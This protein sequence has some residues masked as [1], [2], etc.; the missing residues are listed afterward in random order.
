MSDDEGEDARIQNKIQRLANEGLGLADIM[1]TLNKEFELEAIEKH[2]KKLRAQGKLVYHD[3]K[4]KEERE[5]LFDSQ[6]FYLFVSQNYLYRQ[7]KE[8]ERKKI[9]KLLSDAYRTE[10]I[11]PEAFR[12]GPSLTLE[13]FNEVFDS[14]DY[15]WL[16]ALAPNGFEV[17]NNEEII[18]VCCYT[19]GGVMKIKGEKQVGKLVTI[20]FLAS[21]SFLRYPH[22]AIQIENWENKRYGFRSGARLLRKII[23]DIKYE[24]SLLP[25]NDSERH[26]WI[27]LPIVSTRDSLFAWANNEGFEPLSTFPYPFKSLNQQPKENLKEE[28][29][30]VNC[31]KQISTEKPTEKEKEAQPNPSADVDEV[32]RSKSSN[33]YVEGKMHLPPAW[34]FA[35]Q[36]PS[37]NPSKTQ[38]DSSSQ[39]VK[40]NSSSTKSS[41]GSR[42]TIS[43]VND[44]YFNALD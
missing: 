39:P 5:L 41:I 9:F 12:Q 17:V 4:M 25:E 37:S 31:V 29:L 13:A 35:G 1:K 30:L 44:E 34:R 38:P 40:T 11:S 27:N 14:P 7:P 19:K 42:W 43:P 8:E 3:Q 20:R 21:M 28:V 24:N 23:D 33:I 2:E 18:A 22:G 6:N 36:S 15:E 26:D 16:V 10:T 32:E